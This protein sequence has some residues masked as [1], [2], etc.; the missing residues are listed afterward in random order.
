MR[1][2]VISLR[3]LIG[4]ALLLAAGL[5]LVA[6]GQESAQALWQAG[7]S[8]AKITPQQPVFLAGYASRDKPH[9]GV[10]SEIYVKAL[11]LADG[12]NH[13][14]VIVTSDLIGFRGFLAQRICRR[15]TEATGL[16]RQAI[17]LNSSH[18]HSAPILSLDAQPDENMSPQDVAATHAYT[19]FVEDE[20]VKVVQRA[21]ADLQPCRLSWGSG[22][23]S[24]MINRRE[25]AEGGV[26]IGVNPRGLVDRTVPV[27]R[28]DDAVGKLRAVL[29][30]CA[31]HNTTLTG[32]HY[33]ISGDYAGHAQMFLQ[34]KFPGVQAM[35][36]IGC[37][38]DAN[39]YPR[40]QVELARLHGQ[41][42]G[43]EVSRVLERKLAVVNG[44]L[45]TH[46]AE[47]ALPLQ[48]PPPRE[49][50]VQMAQQSRLSW[51]G[52]AARKMLE[53]LQRGEELPTKYASPIAL[54]QFGRDLSLV[55]LPGE[56]VVDYVP[57][58]ERAIGPQ[59][60][61]LAAYC[62]DVFGYL[63]SAQ[64]L[65]DGGYETRGLIHGGVGVFHPDVQDTVVRAVKQLAEQAGRTEAGK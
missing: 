3:L 33:V 42:L 44:P 14:G 49:A 40:S 55:G 32:E 7:L 17:L 43:E 11:A 18:T 25:F 54:W 6:R 61:W 28:V 19:Q 16:P 22:V 39:P 9:Q 58:I 53:Q 5:P 21:L 8:A 37:G 35:F 15:V 31:C 56:V 50:I 10:E 12:E 27:L 59:K 23:T 26:R 63:P 24:I 1:C 30:G 45:Q 52:W 38:G 48:P 57:L 2:A 51:Q 4:L 60:L 41:S 47:V 46:L 20:V 13:R 64:V 62:N 65:S 29:F 34:Q 36:M